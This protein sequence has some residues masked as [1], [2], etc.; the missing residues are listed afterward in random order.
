MSTLQLVVLTA[1]QMQCWGL[2]FFGIWHCLIG[3]VNE[4]CSAVI[5]KFEQPKKSLLDVWP[6]RLRHGVSLQCQVMWRLPHPPKQ[7]CVSEYLNCEKHC[8]ENLK[9]CKSC[10]IGLF[11]CLFVST[12]KYLSS[13]RWNSYSQC[14]SVAVTQ[15]PSVWLPH[16]LDSVA[17]RWRSR[18]QWHTHKVRSA[19]KYWRIFL[20]QVVHYWQETLAYQHMCQELH[21]CSYT[22]KHCCTKSVLDVLCIKIYTMCHHI[23]QKRENNVLHA[24]NMIISK[25]TQ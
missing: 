2:G 1:K 3:R 24:A 23:M 25:V 10:I 7:C 17:K 20:C 11:V 4:E 18:Q 16:S 15:L 14:K 21:T 19:C 6:R 22:S 9:S 13:R 12:T 5:C 8:F